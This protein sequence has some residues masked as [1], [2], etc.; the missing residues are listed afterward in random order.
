MS[1]AETEPIAPGLFVEEAGAV[2]LLAGRNRE[3][4]RIAFPL[5]QGPAAAEFEP[6]RLARAGI[7]WSWTVQR[8][9]PK[10]PP[11]AGDDDP[12]GFRPFAVGY[13]E[14]PGQVIVESRLLVDDFS[15]L[16][17]GQPMELA[18]EAFRTAA[19]RTVGS[20]AFRPTRDEV[21]R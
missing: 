9:R 10:S 19:G 13:V 8:F 11:Y 15:S 7:L 14:L 16:R 3:D 1:L 12:A 17:I 5:P 18:I 20:Y 6:M 21:A 4:G 2:H